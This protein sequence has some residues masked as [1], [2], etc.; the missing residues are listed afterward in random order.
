MKNIYQISEKIQNDM[1][2]LLLFGK[3]KGSTWFMTDVFKDAYE[4]INNI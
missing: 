4:T 3:S 2:N 1:S